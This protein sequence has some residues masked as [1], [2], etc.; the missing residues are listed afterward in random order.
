MNRTILLLMFFNIYN[1]AL[2]DV[3]ISSY[4]KMINRSVDATTTMHVG[5]GFFCELNKVILNLI[6][7][8]QEGIRSMHVDWT[9]QF[10]PYKD[11]PHENG[12][13]LYFE[14]IQVDL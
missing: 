6:Y 10:F 13:D 9:H 8:E 11:N 14:P 2:V 4:E 1:Y 3:T 7:F 12:W 5:A